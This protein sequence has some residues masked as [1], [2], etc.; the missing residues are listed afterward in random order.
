MSHDKYALFVWPAYAI[1]A[2]VFA[3]MVLDTVIRAGR[4]RRQAERLE[5]D[6][7]R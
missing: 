7:P 3:W 6:D 1:T 5:K 4:W 2:L